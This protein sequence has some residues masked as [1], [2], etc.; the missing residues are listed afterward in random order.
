M[1]L[2]RINGKRL[3]GI[4]THTS[5]I[6]G[7]LDSIHPK[8]MALMHDELWEWIA[9]LLTMIENGADWPSAALYAKSA[10]LRKPNTTGECM[11]HYRILTL[12]S[13]IYRL[14]AKYNCFQFKV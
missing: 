1:H 9:I 2:P 12:T 5:A 8:E 10:F 4:A 11:S 13:V 14:W 6:I 7:G 3:K